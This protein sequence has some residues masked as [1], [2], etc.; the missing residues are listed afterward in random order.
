MLRNPQV[1]RCPELILVMVSV[2]RCHRRTG[3]LAVV[4]V[5]FCGGGAEKRGCSCADDLGPSHVVLRRGCQHLLRSC[6]ASHDF[7]AAAAVASFGT[8]LE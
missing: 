8:G 2:S 6:E 5:K 4:V 7:A 3:V 1:A